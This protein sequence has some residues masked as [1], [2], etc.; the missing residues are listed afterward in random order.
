MPEALVESERQG[1]IAIVTL[2]RPA[3]HNA[4]VPELLSELLRT[5]NECSAGDAAAVV[6]AAQGPS[7]S[8]GGDLRGFYEHRESIGAYAD[9]LVGL[10]NEVILAIWRLPLVT[11]CAVDGQVCGGSLGLLLS[12][13]HVVMSRRSSVAPWYGAIGFNPDGGWRAMLPGVIGARQA[14]QWLAEDVRHDAAYC[15]ELGLAH[16]LVDADALEAGLAWARSVTMME[17]PARAPLSSRRAPGDDGLAHRLAAEKAAFVQKVQS[18]QAL[19]GI[20][21]YL[22][23]KPH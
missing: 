19:R 22:G 16:E 17:S 3:R 7:F 12:C 21:R 13:D 4:L 8:T 9:R 14:E 2:N 6:L 15:F 5:V 11:A 10:L 23:G 1:G 18:V 20:E